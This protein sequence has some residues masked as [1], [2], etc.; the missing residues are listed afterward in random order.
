MKISIY[1]SLFLYLILL[2]GCAHQNS[3]IEQLIERHAVED[4][5]NKLFMA[6]DKKDW[7]EIQRIFTE[8]V[9]F[10]MSSLT[11]EAPALKDSKEIVAVWEKN[12]TPVVAVHHQSGNFLTE[13][14][15]AEATVYCYGMATHYKN[16]ALKNT[17]TWFVGSYDYH[18][19]KSNDGWRIDLI[20][21]NK[22][23]VE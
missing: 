16:P 15:G 10:D 12:L 7:K 14:K 4:T 21:F 6:T 18:L 13:I 20:R 11:G 22:K 17:V 2:S 3:Q 1:F 5:V 19:I 23:Y 8:K 9:Q